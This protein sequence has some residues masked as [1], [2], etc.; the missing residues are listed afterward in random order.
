MTRP[1][2][3]GGR[4]AFPDGLPFV[5][6]ARPPLSAV[7][8]R[9]E[10]SYERGILTNGPLVRELEQAVAERIGVAH[11]VAV[12]SCTSGLMLAFQAL[13]APGGR[14]VMPSFTFSATAHA[15]TW[16]GAIPSFA[17]CGP[18]DAQLDLDDAAGRVDGAAAVVGVHVFGA[19]CRPGPLEK[20]G[21]AAGVPVVF[22]AAHA[23][24]ATHEGRPIGGF[25]DVEVFSLSPTKPL[26]AG[27]GGLVTTADPVLA[28]RIRLGRD[29]GNPGDYDTRFAGLNARMSELHAAVA[30]E[31][32][33][34]L[35]DHLVRRQ[36]LADRYR[37]LL[38][39]LPG[40]RAQ[41]VEPA[42]RSTYKDFTIIVDENAF[43]VPRDSVVAALSADGVDTRCYFSPP[44]HRQHAHRQ[45]EMPH[46]PVTD[47]LAST[48][49][50][51][52][53]WRS[54]SDDAVDGVVDVVARIHEYADEVRESGTL[55]CA[56]S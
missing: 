26:V 17:E 41:H 8:R 25:G 44:V 10:A 14:V 23:F 28:E 55:A 29:Y 9:L 12:A 31:S 15:A 6:P 27:E 4:P 34:D 45:A 18:D 52:P 24:G 54:L 19:P 16:A 22:D 39:D 56:P 36:D 46:L 13:T 30:L 33:R 47:R 3:L 2:L 5:R 32:L 50:S 21:R 48:V 11:A 53:L 38:A 43:G 20:L 1:A 35:D 42:D 49:I 7:S 37:H 51:L 40:L